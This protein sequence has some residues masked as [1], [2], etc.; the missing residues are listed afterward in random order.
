M[1]TPFNSG[2]HL[3]AQ[4]SYPSVNL[5]KL[6]EL[7]IKAVKCDERTSPTSPNPEERP[8]LHFDHER[9][10]LKVCTS[11]VLRRLCKREDFKKAFDTSASDGFIRDF[12]PPK[13]GSSAI[14]GGRLTEDKEEKL[15]NLLRQLLQAIDSVSPPDKT[16]S[17]L[18]LDEPELQ[19]QNLAKKIGGSLFTHIAT[20]SVQSLIFQ[21]QDGALETGKAMAKVISALEQIETRE[22]FEKMKVAISKQLEYEEYEEDIIETAL[23]N[24]ELDKDNYDG[25]INKFFHFIENEALAR[26]RLNICTG[27]M[28]EI[29]KIARL[30]NDTN[31]SLLTSYVEKILALIELSKK[32]PLKIDLKR[33]YGVY[34]EF[35]LDYYLDQAYF[36]SCLAVWP[37]AKTQ[38]FEERTIHPDKGEVIQRE[39]SYRFRINGN[40][41]ETRKP[42]FTSRLNK[43]S[44]RLLAG[45][46][47]AETNSFIINRYL[48]ELIFLDLVIPKTVSTKPLE[49]EQLLTRF[50]AIEEFLR[51][52]GR[53]GIRQLIADLE[54]REANVSKIAT[55]LIGILRE[56]NPRLL[57]KIKER[58]DRKF[59][60]VKRD[61]INWNR[62]ETGQTTGLL[63]GSGKAENEQTE[64]LKKIDII[65]KPEDSYLFSVEVT[66]KLSGYNLVSKAEETSS[67]QGQRV[68]TPSLLQILWV[69]WEYKLDEQTGRRI[70]R[71]VPGTEN[72]HKFALSAA[73]TIEY[74]TA[75]LQMNDK[76]KPNA[77]QYHAATVTAFAVLT[78]VCIWRLIVKLQNLRDSKTFTTLML[79]L[80]PQGK[81]GLEEGGDYVY[82]AAQSIELLLNQDVPLRM[83]GINLENLSPTKKGVKYVQIGSLQALLS[84][85][86]LQLSLPKPSKV[87][88][89][90][91]I[92]YAIRP[93]DEYP[94]RERSANLH[95]L[96]SKSYSATAINESFNGYEIKVEKTD[97]DI[98]SHNSHTDQQRM[99]KEQINELEKQ[100]IGH[101][102]LLS[103]SYGGRKLNRTSVQNNY[104][105][106]T[107][108]LEDVFRHHP[109]I[110]FYP[111]V[112]DV[113]PATRLHTR[114]Q[115]EG[116]FEIA[117]S[118][119]YANFLHDTDPSIERETVR[120]LIPI[121]TFATLSVVEAKDKDSPKFQSGFCT[122]FLIS[123]QK[124]SNRT[125]IE[126]ARQ[127]LVNAD[128]SSE[129]HPALIGLLRSIHYLESEKI[130]G[131]K[132][133][134][135]LNPFSWI[136][137]TS[138]EAAGEV[139]ILSTRR[140]GRILLSYPA[141]LS[142]VSTALH[143]LIK[144]F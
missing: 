106:Q 131:N 54:G 130:S 7:L 88:K 1:N 49:S 78:Y 34:N 48:A 40:N 74:E 59:I 32:E 76:K 3:E 25:Q 28:E 42:A 60:A 36:Y 110:V 94:H 111:L 125:W 50:K 30:A 143:I 75:M 119:D 35:D 103:N 46:Q 66:T 115:H 137:P 139:N 124:V 81:D 118:D 116:G 29:A 128:R 27:I 58:T 69:P 45:N 77:H 98:I 107:N 56:K 55:A 24:L 87:E 39:I 97:L 140:Q 114:Q 13:H 135:V 65:D 96:V 91:I 5:A 85:F 136:S 63:I 62:L 8:L 52:S 6:I 2:A 82:G 133:G 22:H 14:L 113:F 80:Q 17:L 123:D 93:C 99:I 108:F 26:V 120:D 71:Q 86:P 138:K 12:Q 102:I 92:T 141:I 134:P 43:I 44:E 126:K 122:Y 47:Q 132:L 20:T 100:G 23:K 84:A 33:H 129:I 57:T 144:D 121:Y 21:Q 104:L 61:I 37:E 10:R 109:N 112:K 19:L 70:Y 142:H 68:F 105:L 38:I 15:S 67:L 101:I 41:P 9:K 16:L 53:K 11:G 31:S 89:L 51:V 64:W 18:L 72:A 90:G 127:H 79:R 83:Q 95:L 73:I 117:Y 4:A